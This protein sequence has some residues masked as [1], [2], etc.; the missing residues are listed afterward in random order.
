MFTSHFTNY[1]H[2]GLLKAPQKPPQK[3]F[4]GLLLNCAGFKSREEIACH[5]INLM[6]QNMTFYYFNTGIK[7]KYLLF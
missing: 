4:Q 2:R 5:V 1:V 7:I 3:L 6:A